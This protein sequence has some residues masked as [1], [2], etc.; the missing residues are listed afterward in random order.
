MTGRVSDMINRGGSTIAPAEVEA[1]LL[2]LDGVDDAAVFG[3]DD[4]RLGQVPA[5]AIVGA[6][7]PEVL[8][9]LV[10][11]R[12]SG[13]KVPERWVVL[14]ELPRNANGKVDRKALRTRL[15]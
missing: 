15:G 8:R 11:E 9:P 4:E 5:A 7:D 3:I 1:V 13:Y 14:D 6:A 10:R 2:A 12:L